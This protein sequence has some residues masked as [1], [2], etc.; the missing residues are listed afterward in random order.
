MRLL[1]SRQDTFQKRVLPSME[2]VLNFDTLLD[3]VEAK[4]NSKLVLID[5]ISFV[6]VSLK[7][8]EMWNK[9]KPFKEKGLSKYLKPAWILPFYWRK[10][11]KIT[12]VYFLRI[13]SWF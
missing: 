10:Q 13:R 2:M 8:F 7:G 12:T 4:A 1:S 5:K 3:Q 11:E 6:T 9:M